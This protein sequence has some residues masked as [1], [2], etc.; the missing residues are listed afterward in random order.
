CAAGGRLGCQAGRLVVN[1]YT[2]GLGVKAVE[3]LPSQTP[4][5]TNDTVPSVPPEPQ[6]V[7]LNGQKKKSK[8]MLFIISGVILAVLAAGAAY[9]FIL[10]DSGGQQTQQT[11]AGEQQ[12]P[13]E[14]APATVA[15]DP[16]PV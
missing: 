12:Q 8:K 10:K 5:D 3:N 9:W 16:T 14:E 1:L 11:A 15:V 4:T 13:E 2:V 7:P 6:Q